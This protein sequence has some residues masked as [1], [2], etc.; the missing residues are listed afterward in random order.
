MTDKANINYERAVRKQEVF[1]ETNM[2]HLLYMY[3]VHL[4]VC[5]FIY[6]SGY[7][8]PICTVELP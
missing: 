5:L 7:G 6:F 4:I 8:K 1:C 2:C 3:T